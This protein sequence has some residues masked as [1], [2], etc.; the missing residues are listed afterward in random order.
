[1]T[2]D[3]LCIQTERRSHPH[4]PHT[5]DLDANPT[6]Y[7][8]CSFHGDTDGVAT[9]PVLEAVY[10]YAVKHPKHKLVF[11]LDANVYERPAKGQQSH[12]GF[13]SSYVSKG[14]NSAYGLEPHANNYTSFHARTY[15]QPQLNKAVTAEALKTP[16][17]IHPL[18]HLETQQSDDFASAVQFYIRICL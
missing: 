5:P 7:L 2:G 8:I 18:S 10:R 1:M 9:L 16:P 14:L 15:L 13:V 17:P 11:G 6:P 4:A 3:L 12:K